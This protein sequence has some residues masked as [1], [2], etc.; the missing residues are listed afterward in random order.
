MHLSS[1]LAV[2]AFMPVSSAL[3]LTNLTSADCGTVLSSANETYVLIANMDCSAAQHGLIIGAAGITIDGAGHILDGGGADARTCSVLMDEGEPAGQPCRVDSN[4]DGLSSGIF[5]AVAT[6]GGAIP[7]GQGGFDNLTVKNLE[8]TGWCDGIFASGTIGADPDDPATHDLVEG[9]KIDHNVIH[10]NGT[11]C[12]TCFNDAVFTALLGVADSS[13]PNL[14]PI[15]NPG[16]YSCTEENTSVISNNNIWS[17]KGMGIE[18]GPG[19]NGINLQGGVEYDIETTNPIRYSSCVEVHNNAIMKTRLS[20]IMLTHALEGVNMYKNDIEYAEYGGITIPCDFVKFNTIEHNVI[21]KCA[22]VGIGVFDGTHITGNVVKD[23]VKGMD[24]FTAM[25]FPNAGDGI[26]IN[27]GDAGKIGN[28][29]D[30]QDNISCFSFDKDIKVVGG[31]VIGCGD[32]QCCKTNAAADSCHRWNCAC[33][34]PDA[35]CNDPGTGAAGWSDWKQSIA[36][37]INNDG[38]VGYPDYGVMTL[39]KDN[40]YTELW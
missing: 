27:S 18:G 24:R 22:G 7:V 23:T 8:I 17:Q 33:F 21:S 32:N 26:L 10:H 31:S 37:D 36:A 3:A 28:T 19:G 38:V 12:D 13:Y 20:G 15:N 4:G 34:G 16:T 25:G 9:L 29:S 14:T 11:D 2:F 6:A 1:A 39:N 35:D 5:N 30:L 40:K